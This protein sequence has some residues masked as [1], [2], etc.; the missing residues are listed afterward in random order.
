MAAGG[1]AGI[2]VLARSNMIG[3]FVLPQR[4]GVRPTRRQAHHIPNRLRMF[5]S[6]LQQYLRRAFGGATPLLPVAQG[7][8]ADAEQGGKFILRQAIRGTNTFHVRPID[9]ERARRGLFTLQDDPTLTNTRDQL[10]EQILSH[11]YSS[12]TIFLKLRS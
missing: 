9:G 1:S 6:D 3:R 10:V 4:L 12:S 8:N 7:L 11:G 5:G 2:R